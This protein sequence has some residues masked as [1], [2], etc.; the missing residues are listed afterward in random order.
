MDRK[1][2]FHA[3]SFLFSPH[4]MCKNSGSGQSVDDNIYAPYEVHYYS[5]IP[6]NL[7]RKDIVHPKNQF[8]GGQRQGGAPAV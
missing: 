8:Q 4:E 2:Y 3:K 1:I 5:A 6:K 7:R